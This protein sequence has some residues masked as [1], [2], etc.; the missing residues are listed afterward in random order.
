MVSKVNPISKPIDADSPAFSLAGKVII[1]TGGMGGMGQAHARAC[2][3]LGAQTVLVDVVENKSRLSSSAAEP[4]YV[5]AD[6]SSESDWNRVID[7]V[8]H[9][10][11]RLD[12]LVNNAGILSAKPLAETTTS[13]F[14]RIVA[15][16]QRGV[17]LG[18]KA[19]R[20]LLV[21][22][23]GGSIVNISSTAG[24]VGIGDC[25]AYSA[26]KFAVRGMSK[27]AAVE[28]AA[29]GVRVNSIHPGDTLTPMI[30][31]LH[32][33]A[34]VPDVSAIPLGRF[35]TPLEMTGVVCFLLSDAASYITGAEIA[36]DGGYTAA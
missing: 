12:G 32:E 30:Q 4:L 13:D 35:A 7:L 23:G 3:A 17:F 25:F 10:Y 28:L 6:V 19:A 34:A 2:T 1:I 31:G 5:K 26:S 18:M 15:I 16:N 24:L 36:V 14:D 9:E 29:E 8:S 21:E 11:G 22:S 20:P 27:S 33:T